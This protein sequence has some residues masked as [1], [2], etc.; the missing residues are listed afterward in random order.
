MS[1]ICLKQQSMSRR[2]QENATFKLNFIQ[3][4]EK[5][6]FKFILKPY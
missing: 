6:L 1:I 4:N 2:D 3:N 5:A